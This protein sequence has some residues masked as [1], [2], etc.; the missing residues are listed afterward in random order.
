MLSNIFLLLFIRGSYNCATNDILNSE[1]ILF[2]SFYMAYELWFY[3]VTQ[4]SCSIFKQGHDKL[5]NTETFR[6]QDDTITIIFINH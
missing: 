3:S 1:G 6:K 2:L 5:K 4:I